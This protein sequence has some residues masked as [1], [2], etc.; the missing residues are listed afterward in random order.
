MDQEPPRTQLDDIQDLLEESIELAKENKRMLKAMRREALIGGVVKTLLWVGA[1]GLSLYFTM[2]YLGP[3]LGPAA[4]AASGLRP[5]DYQAL[6]DFYK[7]Q[8]GE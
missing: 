3:L 6:F 7:G 2:Q 1:I 4:D 5:Q 8:T